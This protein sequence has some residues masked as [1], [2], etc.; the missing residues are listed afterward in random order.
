MEIIGVT[1]RL[2]APVITG[3]CTPN[4]HTPR[5]WIR[6]ATP[7]TRRLEL[8]STTG[9]IDRKMERFRDDQ[10]YGDISGVHDKNMLEAEQQQAVR[11]QLF[12][13]QLKTPN[14]QFVRHPI[15]VQGP[16]EVSSRP[17]PGLGA[18]ATNFPERLDKTK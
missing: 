16:A 5:H 12:I 14:S 9:L 17:L 4:F 15:P 8:M 1:E 2:V 11:R 18:F 6:V 13:G 10:G 3:K 7:A